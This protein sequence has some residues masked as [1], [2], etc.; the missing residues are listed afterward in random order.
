M[1]LTEAEMMTLQDLLELDRDFDVQAAESSPEKRPQ[2]IRDYIGKIEAK[3]SKRPRVKLP[4]DCDW[5]NTEEPWSSDHLQGRL[6]LLDFFTYCCINCMHIL[7]DLEAIE[8]TFD[9]ETIPVLGVHSAKFENERVSQNIESAIQ[10]YGI[11]HPVVNDATASLWQNLLIS[12]WPT[13]LLLDP[14]GKPLKF[15]VGEGHREDII[16]FVSVAK[17]VYKDN[18]T[19]DLRLPKLKLGQVLNQTVLKYPGNIHVQENNLFIADTGNHRILKATL[20]GSVQEVVGDGVRGHADGELYKTRFNSPQGMMFVNGILYV[21]DTGNHVIRSIDFVNKKT[22]TIA[23][24]G[25][26]TPTGVLV[27]DPDKSALEMTLA[28]PWDLCL[29]K[30]GDRLMIAMAG[31]HQIWSYH[32]TSKQLKLEAG[33]GKE[34]NRNNSYPLKASFAQ[35][36]G[37][38]LDPG[39]G[40][41]YVADSESSSVRVVLADNKGVKNIAGG[42][43]D[44]TDLFAYGD[45]DGKG[46]DAKLQH[47]LSVA[48]KDDKL[49]VADSYNHK[50]KVITELKAK[51][52]MCETLV[53]DNDNFD[54]PGGLAVQGNNIFIADTNHHSVKKVNLDSLEVGDV[55]L[56]L[57]AREELDSG[58]RPASVASKSDLTADINP[59]DFDFTVRLTLDPD[60]SLNNSAPNAWKV[61]LPDNSQWSCQQGIKA[62]IEGT[63]PIQFNLKKLNQAS[64]NHPGKIV[65]TFKLYLCSNSN[66]T[67]SVQTKTVVLNIQDPKDDNLTNKTNDFVLDIKP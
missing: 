49:Y 58:A 64:H 21:C 35:P 34:E 4:S 13:L 10:R 20:D 44:P 28:S 60:L 18:L 48:F 17:E 26:Q 29:N 56:E 61:A 1:E 59:G 16:E 23:G 3:C 33:T 14:N 53:F 9:S 22:A 31:S 19:K 66:G 27:Q 8:E 46:F 67:C 41:L 65:I 25:I 57:P 11:A 24:N 6:T 55:V 32:L 50:I 37:L 63:N 7:P 39:T 15:F 45:K 62:K 40:D 2:L 51:S 42:G 5:F 38:A 30:D 12:C 52:A 47:P 36:S 54:E 43:R